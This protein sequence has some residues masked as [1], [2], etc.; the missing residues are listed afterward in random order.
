MSSRH[1]QCPNLSG[2]VNRKI[3]TPLHGDQILWDRT[4]FSTNLNRFAVGEKP[5]PSM[6]ILADKYLTELSSLAKQPF[7]G[8]RGG[9]DVGQFNAASCR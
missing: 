9:K 2:F 5:H 4:E 1:L 7:P 8:A 6:R 3:G